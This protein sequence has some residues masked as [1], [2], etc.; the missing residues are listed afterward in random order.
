MNR[1]RLRNLYGLACAVLL[2]ALGCVTVLVVQQARAHASAT[3]DSL[4]HEDIR[5][6]LWRMETRV[7]SMV[8]TTTV[9]APELGPETSYQNAVIAPAEGLVNDVAAPAEAVRNEI[10]SA[11]DDAFIAACSLMQPGV[12]GPDAEVPEPSGIT[13][14]QSW[15]NRGASRSQAEFRARQSTSNISQVV[16]SNGPAG[17][18]GEP[19]SAD[20]WT[21]GPLAP[22]WSQEDDELQLYLAR[23]VESDS[24]VRHESY[25]LAWKELK[26]LLLAEVRDLFPEADLVPMTGPGATQVLDPNSTPPTEDDAF[27]LAAIPVR[28][29]ACAP[30][31]PQLAAG[32]FVA[33]GVGWVALLAGLGLGW[34]ALSASVAYG[35]KHRRFTHAVTHELRTPL[36]TFRMYSEMLAKGMVPESAQPEYLDTLESES[37]RLSGLVENVLRYAQLEEG[38]GDAAPLEELSGEAILRRI[39]PG[40]R[41]LCE[42]FDATLAIEC[43]SASAVRASVDI[44]AVQQILT[45]VVENACKYGRSDSGRDPRTDVEL[46]VSEAGDGFAIDIV[47]SGPGI[48]PSLARR[49]F[50]PFERAGRDSSDP[51]P[52]VGLGL[53]LARDLAELQGG[54]LSLLPSERGA[55]FRLTI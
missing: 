48:D 23:R 5:T 20:S 13:P 15:V 44:A 33:L 18:G 38:G 40:L 22:V 47:D 3:A 54:S 43:D 49:I 29:A 16:S 31:P 4:Y 41:Q 26:G 9:R 45:N 21:M 7:G 10:V 51:T 34:V 28:L 6:A 37:Q 27:R 14:G 19:L 24:G 12:S 32:P 11:A 30:A 35:D 39:E 42:R 50:E 8:A 2:A 1:K 17:E 25:R 55:R 53:A 52:G 36:T 46:R